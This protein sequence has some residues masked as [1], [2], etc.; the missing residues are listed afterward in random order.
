MTGRLDRTAQ[1]F[2]FHPLYGL[3]F[4]IVRVV[5]CGIILDDVW[6]IRYAS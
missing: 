3:Y 5:A 1:S 6:T 4:L 2:V